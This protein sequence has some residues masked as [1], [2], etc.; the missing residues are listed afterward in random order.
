MLLK[1]DKAAVSW[2]SE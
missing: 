2:C 1:L